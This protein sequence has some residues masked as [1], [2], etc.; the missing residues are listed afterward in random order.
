M[1]TWGFSLAAI[2][3]GSWLWLAL[4]SRRLA[5]WLSCS[6]LRR[7][8]QYSYAIYLVHLPVWTVLG[9]HLWAGTLLG[10][11]LPAQLFAWVLMLGISLALG[12]LSW[13]LI[14]RHAL[15]LKRYFPSDEPHMP[16][17]RQAEG[18]EALQRV[19]VAQIQAGPRVLLHRRGVTER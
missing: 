7:L 9:P 2:L 14:E 8:G 16:S 17:R 3:F 5:H 10:S 4:A 18:A 19:G 13:N 6:V 1:D 11:R 15:A 12:W